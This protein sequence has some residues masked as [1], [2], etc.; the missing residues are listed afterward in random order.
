MPVDGKRSKVSTV[1]FLDHCIYPSV[2]TYQMTWL[3]G[4]LSYD[5][6][7]RLGERREEGHAETTAHN[8]VLTRVVE[9]LEDSIG[10]YRGRKG[11]DRKGK[12]VLSV[13]I[14]PL[15]TIL[16]HNTPYVNSDHLQCPFL[17]PSDF[18]VCVCV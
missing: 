11:L 3:T 5:C 17:S 13:V 18:Q 16:L 14:N 1:N 2:P 8:G 7:C 15:S 4:S 6:P 12:V 10:Q 9:A